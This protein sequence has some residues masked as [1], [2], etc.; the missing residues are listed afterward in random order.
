MCYNRGMKRL[1]GAVKTVRALVVRTTERT[2]GVLGRIKRDS[3][4]AML[5]IAGAVAGAISPMALD[6]ARVMTPE[7][8][9][10]FERRQNGL[11]FGR[12]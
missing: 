9:A 12:D 4:E 10:A 2:R 7:Q 11:G 8:Q 6:H 3:Q 1:L 5:V